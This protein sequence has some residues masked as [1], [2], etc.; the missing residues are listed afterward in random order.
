MVVDYLAM[1]T[2]NFAIPDFCLPIAKVP[3][4]AAIF[5]PG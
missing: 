1:S 4:L 2:V 5:W 3:V